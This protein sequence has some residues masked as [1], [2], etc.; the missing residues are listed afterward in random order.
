M[1]CG[2]AVEMGFPNHKLQDLGAN[3]F[4][5]R[6][7]VAHLAA[8]FSV[9]DP[10]YVREF[11]ETEGLDRA[12]YEDIQDADGATMAASPGARVRSLARQASDATFHF[13]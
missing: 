12:V 2:Q 13:V 7:Y 9:I 3:A 4:D 1:H 8:I 10:D 6:V 11:Y 5:G